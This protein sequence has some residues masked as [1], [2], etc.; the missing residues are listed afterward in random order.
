MK[1]PTCTLWAVL[2][3]VLGARE[4]SSAPTPAS[5]ASAKGVVI[6]VSGASASDE[7]ASAA[8]FTK[9]ETFGM[10]STFTFTDGRTMQVA[11]TSLKKVFMY[12]DFS[13]LTLVTDSD[14]KG[15]EGQANQAG[16]VMTQ[17]PK[18][19]PVLAAFIE[20]VRAATLRA[21]E[22]MV[23]VEGRWMTQQQYQQARTTSPNNYVAVLNVNGKI[24]K[25]AKA[26]S[27]DG[28]QLKIMHDGGFATIVVTSLS[29]A[30]KQELAKTDAN[31]GRVLAP[32]IAGTLPPPTTRSGYPFSIVNDVV[33]VQLPDGQK[34]FALDRVPPSLTDNDPN[35]AKEVASRL[36]EKAKLKK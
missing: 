23:V 25:N 20:K 32:G 3:I 27:L 8:E 31:I 11:P 35:L 19:A 4:A 28:G 14:W 21:K 26:L 2:L 10:T 18:S 13:T 17:Y 36:A 16:A 29:D 34:T 24:Y 5:T 33:T 22:G 1:N 15:L 9:M 30:Q 12:P 6:Y 7:F